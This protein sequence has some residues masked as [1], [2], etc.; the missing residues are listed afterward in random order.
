MRGSKQDEEETARR[1]LLER[2]RRVKLESL[3]LQQHKRQV[4]TV[5]ERSLDKLEQGLPFVVGV[6]AETIERKE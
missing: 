3:T 1:E 5:I 2:S 4:S 6:R